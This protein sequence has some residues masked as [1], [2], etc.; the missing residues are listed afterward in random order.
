MGQLPLLISTAL[1]LTE[2]QVDSITVTW[3]QPL[4]IEQLLPMISC[5]LHRKGLQL[6]SYTFR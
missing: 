1:H 2:L 6:D 5:A 3:A 4:G